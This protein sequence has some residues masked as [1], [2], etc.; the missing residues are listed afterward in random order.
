MNGKPSEKKG[1][2]RLWAAFIYSLNGLKYAV[3]KETA[4]LQETVIYIILLP[5]IYFMPLPITFKSILFSANTVVLVT[6]LLNSAVESIVDIASPEYN[7]LAK[8]AKDLASAAVFVSILLAAALWAFAAV[9]V[10]TET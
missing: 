2:A 1:A 5:V 9:L 10:F 6:E 7:E 4:F 3:T 8:R